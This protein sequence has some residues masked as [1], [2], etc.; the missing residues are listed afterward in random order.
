LATNKPVT[1]D[2]LFGE[3]SVSAKPEKWQVIH[4]KPQREKKLADYLKKQNVY[5]YLPMLDSIRQYKY[6]KVSFTKPMF[7]GYVFAR[8]ASANKP[9]ILVSGYVVSFLKVP[10]EEE[11]LHDLIQIQTG[12]AMSAE[13]QQC[14]WLEMG[15]QVEIISGPMQGMQGIVKSQNNLE[16]VNL[17]VNILRQAISV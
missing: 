13:M 9:S 10:S 12:R 3:L 1:V 16:E 7:P 11:L 2:E 14:A 5:Y 6:R 17:Q 15:W 8:F 4:V